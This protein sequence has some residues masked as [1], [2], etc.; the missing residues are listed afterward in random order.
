M[1][2]CCIWIGAWTITA[3]YIM[4]VGELGHRASPLN[5]VTTV[6]WT[7]QTRYIFLYHLFGGLWVNAFIIGCS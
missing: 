5:F 4:S 3:V 2:V 6:V 7:K 1:L